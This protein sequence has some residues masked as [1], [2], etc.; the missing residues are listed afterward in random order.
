[1]PLR[2]KVLQPPSCRKDEE[3]AV[4]PSSGANIRRPA[5]GD[6]CRAGDIQREALRC[7]K[8]RMVSRRQMFD[9]LHVSR[10][11]DIPWIL[12]PRDHEAHVGQAA[13]GL[14]QQPLEGRLTIRAVGTEIAEIPSGWAINRSIPCFVD[15]AVQRAGPPSC[16]S[17]CKFD[18]LSR[19]I[20]MAFPSFGKL[21]CA[22][23][24][25]V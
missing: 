22:A 6:H 18:P 10:P 19:G 21:D 17:A 23:V 2:V 8:C 12:R 25:P 15:R 24:Q 20:S 14:Q 5:G 9:P 11:F 16:V 7:V 13:R 1:M 3:V 4:F